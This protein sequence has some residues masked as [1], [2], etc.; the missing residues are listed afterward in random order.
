M[1]FH[2]CS[3]IN[4]KTI[5]LPN[6]DRLLPFDWPLAVASMANAA[7]QNFIFTLHYPV[8]YAWLDIIRRKMLTSSAACS[9]SGSRKSQFRNGEGFGEFRLVAFRQRSAVY[10]QYGITRD[11][12]R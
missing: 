5:A 1:P 11:D 3:N 7:L 4:R 2:V 9:G 6:R 8:L 10:L 12:E